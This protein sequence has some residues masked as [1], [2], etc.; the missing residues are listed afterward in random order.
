MRRRFPVFRLII[1]TI[2]AVLLFFVS[3]VFLNIAFGPGAAFAQWELVFGWIGFI[4]RVA[5]QVDFHWLPML[6]Y[7]VGVMIVLEGAHRFFSWIYG[8]KHQP[9]ASSQDSVKP[10]WHRRWT[11]G[12]CGLALTSTF[13]AMAGLGIIHQTGW[14]LA[15]DTR[16]LITT[17]NRPLMLARMVDLEMRVAESEG[18]DIQTNPETLKSILIGAHW[19][20][21]QAEGF[22]VF[23]LRSDD[24]LPGVL[25]FREQGRYEPAQ[26]GFGVVFDEGDMHGFRSE[27]LSQTIASYSDRMYPIQ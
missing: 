22:R 8:C 11:Y 25:V 14:M 15:A 7:S 2:T 26:R 18:T 19:W 17:S 6:F 4:R 3:I 24:N 21:P 1:W 13:I 27:D 12:I 20:K 10:E 23:I 16:V 5:S 9:D